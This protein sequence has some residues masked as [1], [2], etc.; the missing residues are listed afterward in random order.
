MHEKFR[1]ATEQVHALYV[2]LIKAPAIKVAFPADLK[3]S[4]PGIYV[5]YEA[6]EAVHVGRTR[7]VAA[8]LRAHL[9]KSHNS[10][11]FAFKRARRALGRKATYSPIGSRANLLLEPDFRAEFYRQIDLIR[12]M[13][14]RFVPVQ[15]PILQYLLE[16]YVHIALD[17][18]LD[19][20][21]TH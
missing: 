15:D 19:E 16:L 17:L 20:F 4:G 8:R 12:S 3:S 1:C 2:D 11:S 18:P 6:G 14:V 21:D 10:A 13:D 5:F 9:T 7:N